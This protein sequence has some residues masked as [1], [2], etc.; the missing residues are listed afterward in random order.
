MKEM[1]MLLIIMY[2]NPLFLFIL[3][4]KLPK[5]ILGSWTFSVLGIIVT[6]YIIL[7]IFI[8]VNT[9]SLN[10][11]S[12]IS[13]YEND[14]INLLFKKMKRIKIGLIPYW[15]IIIYNFFYYL[16]VVKSISDYLRLI[17]NIIIIFILYTTII[18]S[19]FF[20]ITFLKKLHKNKILTNKNLILHS[21]F[22]LTLMLDIIDTIIIIRKYSNQNRT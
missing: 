20:S 8:Y 22:Q 4:S 2:T 17:D 13:D 10:L 16:T 14:N 19:S 7:Y 9:A 15:I 1:N 18:L 12:L 11:K 3:M 5:F 21:I 6:V